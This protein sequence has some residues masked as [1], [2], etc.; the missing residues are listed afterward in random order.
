MKMRQNKPF[1]VT[2]SR[3]QPTSG[4]SDTLST[5][6]DYYRITQSPGLYRI[7]MVARAPIW[8]NLL[9]LAWL[10]PWT[11]FTAYFW[12]RWFGIVEPMGRG[13]DSLG[14]AIAFSF[15]WL[16]VFLIVAFINFYVIE[17][18]IYSDY[19]E[20]RLGLPGVILK[21]TVEK[22][23]VREIVIVKRN[24]YV[25]ESDEK[26]ED[27]WEL[28]IDGQTARELVVLGAFTVAS[29]TPKKAQWTIDRAWTP[30]ELQWLGALVAKWANKSLQ[31]S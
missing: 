3:V 13:G 5:A 26:H 16:A 28:C 6:P 14:G 24:A 29:W 2:D 8:V 21:T 11:G 31:T 25:D 9:L 7:Q 23:S 22:R 15:F 1:G 18:R 20:D 27:R 30:D 17:T 19:M 12:A 4:A 10:V